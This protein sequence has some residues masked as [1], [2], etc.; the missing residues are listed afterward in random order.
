M[1]A[2]APSETPRFTLLQPH[3]HRMCWYRSIDAHSRNIGAASPRT[4][5]LEA[6]PRGGLAGGGSARSSDAASRSFTAGPAGSRSPGTRSHGTRSP[7]TGSRHGSF[8][9]ALHAQNAFLTRSTSA[10]ANA[11]EHRC[12]ACHEL[13]VYAT[14]KPRSAVLSDGA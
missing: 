12:D 13:D 2:R 9:G 3:A 11:D 6:M 5:S 10:N 7:G 14:T 1:Y 4:K 8:T